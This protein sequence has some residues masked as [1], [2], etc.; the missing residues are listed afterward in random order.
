M[1]SAFRC[2]LM[3]ITMKCCSTT[4]FPPYHRLCFILGTYVPGEWS[5]AFRCNPMCCDRVEIPLVHLPKY[6]IAFT[7]LWL[8]FL[9]IED[10]NSV[11]YSMGSFYVSTFKMT[12][13]QKNSQSNT[14]CDLNCSKVAWKNLKPN[15]NAPD[16]IYDPP[17][18]A[19]IL[20]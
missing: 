14:E 7:E 2:N 8:L 10:R 20:Q 5:S 18:L 19:G 3:L 9:M 13:L 4:E 1:N 11:K 16:K 17:F 12:S 6:Y 15:L